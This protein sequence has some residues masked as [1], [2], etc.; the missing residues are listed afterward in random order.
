MF[1]IQ[2]RMCVKCPNLVKFVNIG[3]SEM[4]DILHTQALL[5]ETL[6]LKPKSSA[7]KHVVHYCRL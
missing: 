2:S 5:T 4:L 6:R 7:Y 1:N 3:G